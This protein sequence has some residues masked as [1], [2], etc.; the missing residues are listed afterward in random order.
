LESLQW[1]GTAQAKPFTH[2]IGN[3]SGVITVDTDGTVFGHGIYD[4]KFN[5][6]LKHDTNGVIRPYALSLF[7]PAPRNV[8][9]I[10][11]SSGSWAQIIA[12]NPAVAS[13]TI[14]EINPGCLDL[15]AGETE[16]TSVPKVVA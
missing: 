2:V 6:D 14:V 16:V 9:M 13:L 10:G 15:I 12:N 11:L 1:N 3:R 7:H 5:T 8:L 4:G